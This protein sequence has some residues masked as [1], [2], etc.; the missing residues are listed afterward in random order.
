M[1]RLLLVSFHFPPFNAIAAVRTGKFAKFLL[2]RG[3]DVRVIAARSDAAQNLPLEIPA[4]R[5]LHT[6]WTHVDE[7]LDRFLRLGRTKATEAP[8]S[9]QGGPSPPAATATRNGG[10]PLRARIRRKLG[11]LRTALLHVPDGRIAWM[12]EALRGATAFLGDWKPDI[13]Y[14]SAPPTTTL[15]VA[16]AL[17]HRFDVP[18]VAEFRDLWTDNPYYE[19]PDWRRRIE[20]LWERRVIG[21]AAALVTVSSIWR[22]KLRAKFNKP[23][24]LAMNGYVPTD[25][26]EGL[27]ALPSTDG[28][29]HILY[30][31]MI[32]PGYRDP[33]P[34][35]E[36]IA[37][38]GPQREDVLVE[39]IG[40]DLKSVSELAGKAG[41][42]DRVRIEPPVKYRD[43]LVRQTRADVLLHLQWNDPK[44]SGTISGKLFEYFGAR[45]PVLGLGYD[46]GEVASLLAAHARGHVIND[47]DAIADQLR[48]WIAEKRA[49]GVPALVDD[50]VLGLTRDDQFVNAE[51]MALDVLGR[52][53]PARV[54]A[55]SRRADRLTDP[56]GMIATPLYRPLDTAVLGR[57]QLC[58]V[59]DTEEQFDWEGPF[60]RS[61]TAVTAIRS[62]PLAQRIFERYR[63]KPAYLLDYPIATSELGRRL[64]NEW[65]EAGVC[66]IGAQLHAWVNPPHVEEV[67]TRNSFAGNLPPGLERQKLAALVGEIRDA[68]GIQPEIFKAGRYGLGPS[69]ATTLEMLGFKVDTSVLPYTDLRFK[70]GPDFRCFTERPFAF[71]ESRALL[72]LPVT[73]AFLGSAHRVA[74][75]IFP[76]VDSERRLPGVA[77]GLLAR[78]NLVDRVTLTPEGI[79]FDQMRRLTRDLLARGERLFVLSFHSPSLE[80]GHTP[81]VVDQ[82]TRDEFLAR[83][84]RYMEFFFGELGGEATSPLAL[85]DRLIP[86]P[87][88]TR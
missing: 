43:S 16:R 60:S 26:P 73:R 52:R 62:L 31:G 57:P 29:L 22:D 78:A 30:T 25:F 72:Q 42:A 59:I 84:E 36:A 46:R 61:N 9:A 47:P 82:K 87:A 83:L 8:A 70:F 67:T 12:P 71:G 39:F 68:L 15:L 69:T 88:V 1:K 4:E 81:Y 3:W 77:R 44:E 53:V 24:A 19:F 18:W 28:P 7:M 23:V 48:R 64:F 49:G 6:P 38:L 20:R 27:P 56:T 79:D 65:R 50:A 66:E 75:T 41:V 11:E 21:D 17:A 33:L 13:V 58:V 63:I 55:T 76:L 80:A 2:E 34:L 74:E 14:A 32:Y 51:R 37:R 5:V 45:R 85:H 35:F 54:V 86:P 10:R 40:T